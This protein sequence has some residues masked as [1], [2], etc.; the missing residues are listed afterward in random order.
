MFPKS[1]NF[2]KIEA[3]A[4]GRGAAKIAVCHHHGMTAMGWV[5]GNP[6][7]FLTT[8]DGTGMGSVERRICWNKR[9]TMAPAAMKK[10]NHGMQAVDCFDSGINVINR[11]KK[12]EHR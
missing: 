4:A 12:F 3:Q 5:D 2:S 10:Y 6:V 9:I 8:V 7:H 11:L 1:V